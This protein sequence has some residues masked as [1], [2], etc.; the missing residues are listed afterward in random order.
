MLNTIYKNS[1]LAWFISD[2]FAHNTDLIS[3]ARKNFR[4]QD[5]DDETVVA[6]Q[7]DYVWDTEWSHTSFLNIPTDISSQ[8]I[9]AISANK[10]YVKVYQLAVDATPLN[11]NS[12]FT[13]RAGKKTFKFHFH[14]TRQPEQNFS[15]FY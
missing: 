5:T 8:A 4:P 1:F 14:T 3:L 9:S 6:E 7:T 2:Y 12:F 11:Y 15:K 13:D 10:D